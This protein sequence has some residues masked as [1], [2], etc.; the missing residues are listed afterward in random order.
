MKAIGFNAGQYGDL[1]MNMVAVRQFKTMYPDSDFT[2]GIGNKYADCQPVFERSP[3]ISRIHIWDSYDKWPSPKDKEFLDTQK[4]DKV[5]EAMPHH[6][7]HDW[8]LKRH[9]TQEVCHMHGLPIPDDTQ[10][11]LPP[12]KTTP[13]SKDFIAIAGFT[14]FGAAKSLPPETLRTICSLLKKIGYDTL[15]LA[16][17]GEPD[18]GASYRV[19]ASYI[20]AV[21]YMLSC[22]ALLCADTGMCWMASGFKHPVVGLYGYSFYPG[23]TT[24]ANWQPTNPN[25]I[26]LESKHVRGIAV[27]SII[28]SVRAL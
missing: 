12:I 3:L 22:K 6:K 8:Y 14:S 2:L 7:E 28:D 21:S 27:D 26:Y 23:A 1:A 4:F 11:E 20:L 16:V 25:A 24:S 17:R 13:V 18:I 19:E 9:Q 15:Q 5:F 10:I